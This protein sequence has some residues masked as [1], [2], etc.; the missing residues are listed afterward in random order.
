[1]LARCYVARVLHGRA[2]EQSTIERLL[3]D[4]GAGAS[5]ALVVRGELGIGKTALLDHAA[6]AASELGMRVLRCTG[7]ESEVEL[8][9]AALHLLLRPFLPLAERLPAPQGAAL[10]AAFGLSSERG[11]DRFLVGL[12]ALGILSELA[13][14]GPVLCLMDDAHW[15]DRPSADALLFA[16]RRLAGE[17]VVMLFAADEGDFAAG[18]LP[19]LRLDGLD[20]QAALALVGTDRPVS[21]VLERLLHEAGGNPLALAELSAALTPEQRGGSLPDLPLAANG[22]PAPGRAR[23]AFDAR[24]DVLPDPTRAMLLV[25]AADDTGELRVICAAAASFG[26]ELPDLKQAEDA[27]LVR[28]VDTTLTFRHPL[29][30]M[31]AYH[32]APAMDR[33]AAHRA[34]AGVLRGTAHADRRTWHRAAAVTG[35]D[36]RTARKLEA[37]ARRAAE[38]RGHATAA[39]AFERAAE[40]STTRKAAAARFAAAARSAFDAG[41]LDQAARLAEEARSAFDARRLDQAGFVDRGR[42]AGHDLARLRAAIAFEQGSPGQASRLLL[43]G[44]APLGRRE[45]ES[46]A[47]MLAEAAR[48]AWYAG[49]A[50]LA[51]QAARA[52]GALAL[53]DGSPCGALVATI[54]SLADLL[55]G[56]PATGVAR[57]REMVQASRH[58][59]P[60]DPRRALVLVAAGL[61]TA[62]HHG[63]YELAEA[64]VTDCRSRGLIGPLPGSLFAMARTQLLLGRHREAQATA[65]EGLHLARDTGQR[66]TAAHLGSLLAWLAA[67]SGEPSP[68]AGH[69]PDGDTVG[70]A[71]ATWARGLDDLGAGRYDTALDRLT[72]GWSGRSLIA[73]Y[74]SVPDQVEAAT[75]CGRTEEVAAAFRRFEAW[76]DQTGRP[77]PQAV[78]HRCRALLAATDEDRETHFE[79][80][81]RAH[82]LD[83]HPYEQARTELIYGQWMRRTRRRRTARTLLHAARE[84]FEHLGARPWARR[85]GAELRATGDPLTT[86]AERSAPGDL[87]T[88]QERQ[89]ARLASRGV[90]NRDIAAQLFLSPRTVGN[91]LYNTFR[92][93]GIASRRDLQEVLGRDAP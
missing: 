4:A 21:W 83:P 45:P 80:A 6:V 32:R 30:R 26:A 69:V 64:L 56:E 13:G 73:A 46:A 15:M 53:P 43:E 74:L 87:L 50:D 14:E 51:R 88:A 91:H 24:L 39:A 66:H 28:V 65:L 22:A 12:A 47:L 54:S 89:V 2:V 76:A 18:M 82:A 75:R 11:G 27:S 8:P 61:A 10:R 44:A 41:Q 85:A 67:V 58:S 33:M 60:A 55:L 35:R 5:A 42:E 57:I 48:A 90:S 81:L 29:I 34:L 25:A 77:T 59:P 49:D 52:L 3:T 1:V 20:R 36:E 16:A 37:T 72:D 68:T 70:S 62:D 92:K 19:E 79:A 93:L 71:L 40:L 84:R 78:A 7:V 31:A 86:R 63:S 9:F 17:G 23:H 38:R